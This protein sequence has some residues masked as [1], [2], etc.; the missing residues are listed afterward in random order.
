MADKTSLPALEREE[1]IQLLQGY[2][3]A[4]SLEVGEQGET[5]QIEMEIDTGDAPP[6]RQRPCR[7]P[8]AVRREVS[9]QLRSMQSSGVI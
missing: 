9:K 5:D 8:F 7:M 1:L 6:C 4:F 3:L 2:H